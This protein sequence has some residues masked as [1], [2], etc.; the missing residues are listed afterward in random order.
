MQ[1]LYH[2]LTTF[3]PILESYSPDSQGIMWFSR[4]RPFKKALKALCTAHA[5]FA[6]SSREIA[7]GRNAT[8]TA[9]APLMH[10]VA[11]TLIELHGAYM[12]NMPRY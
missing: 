2:L 3:V 4:L 1:V 9:L 5:Q 11:R 12:A 8:F 6:E 10:Q 7:F